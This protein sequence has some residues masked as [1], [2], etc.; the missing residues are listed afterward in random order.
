MDGWS[1]GRIE[2]WKDGMVKTMSKKV[3]HIK[4][5]IFQ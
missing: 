4:T 5:I 3:V 2:R 1:D